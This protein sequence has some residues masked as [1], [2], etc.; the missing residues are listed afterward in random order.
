MKFTVQHTCSKKG[1]EQQVLKDFPYLSVYEPEKGKTPFLGEGYYFWD[2]N[3]EYAKVWGKIHYANDYFI[4]EAD[5]SVDHDRD[6]FFLDLAGNREH[7][8]GFV[9]LLLEFNLID[10]EGAK[11]IDL[12]WIIDYLRKECPPEVFPFEVIRAVDY[13]NDEQVG[14]KIVFNENKKSH[15]ILNPR[16]I[17]SFK[18]KKNIV[19]LRNPI[20][21]FTS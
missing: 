6:G 21:A 1:G 3:F 11:G 5:I 2:Y 13:N 10:D 16:I 20:I 7:L 15:T 12:C 14:I 4:C 9:D 8:V 19:Y 17:L 18:N